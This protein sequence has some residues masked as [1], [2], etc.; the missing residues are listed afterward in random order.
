MLA[1]QRRAGTEPALSV[2]GRAWMRASRCSSRI[3]VVHAAGTDLEAAGQAGAGELCHLLEHRGPHVQ[4][5]FLA[6]AQLLVEQVRESVAGPRPRLDG[7]LEPL[8]VVRCE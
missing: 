2:S 7:E 3:G 8:A 6:H 4:L 1:C 5:D